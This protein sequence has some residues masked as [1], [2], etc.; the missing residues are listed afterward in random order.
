MEK[1]LFKIGICAFIGVVCLVLYVATRVAKELSIGGI[2][3]SERNA[4]I[5]EFVLL[6]LCL[7]VAIL[8]ISMLVG[9]V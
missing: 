7:V 9:L 3:R 1:L 4:C 6:G 2:A 5:A 8:G